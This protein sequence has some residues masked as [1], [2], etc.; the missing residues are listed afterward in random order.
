MKYSEFI[1]QL[2]GKGVTFS[3]GKGGHMKATYMGNKSVV[4]NHGSKEI[5]EGLRLAIL[6]QLGIK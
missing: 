2:K 4:P 1:K 6:K 5:G 3:K